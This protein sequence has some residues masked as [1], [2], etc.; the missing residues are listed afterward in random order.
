MQ[1]N[2]SN[3]ILVQ[4]KLLTIHAFENLKS[5][6]DILPG[7][8]GSLGNFIVSDS[9]DDGGGHFFSDLRAIAACL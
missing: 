8:I 4:T 9:F 3:I 1:W 7:N 2:L 5:H 6:N